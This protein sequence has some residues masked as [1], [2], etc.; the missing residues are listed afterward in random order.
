[1]RYNRVFLF[2][3]ADYAFD[4]F[5]VTRPPAGLG[6]VAQALEDNGT[7]YDFIDLRFGQSF[8]EIKKRIEGFKPDLVG[9]SMMTVKYENV[10]SL[11]KRVHAIGGFDIIFGGPHTS[12]LE[13]DVI[14][15][16][17]EIKY[18][19]VGEGEETIVELCR[20][21]D[22]RGIKGIIFQENGNIIKNEKRPF[23]QDIEKISF[24]RYTNFHLENYTKRAKELTLSTSRGCPY[25][26]IFCSAHLTIGKL[27]RQRSP[28]HVANEIE[29]WYS[30]GYRTFE[31]SDE[32]F[33]FNSR[34]IYEICDEIEKRGLKGLTFNIGGG[35]R[36]DRVDRALLKRMKEVGFRYIAIGVE[37]GN[38][39]I[40]E[41]LKKGEKIETIKEAIKNAHELGYDIGLFFVLG[42]P[43]ETWQDIEDAVAVAKA[44]PIKNVFFFNLLPQPKTELYEWIEK[45][46][47]FVV[48]PSKYLN[49]ASYFNNV[50]LY[51][52][53]SMDM[54]QRKKALKYTKNVR[55]QIRRGFFLCPISM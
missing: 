32:N 52:T 6:Y 38:N 34:R 42:V 10:Y 18:A 20:G 5:R 30:R 26:C 39:K 21:D 48:P 53:D 45:H 4:R 23:M 25:S 27:F 28:M 13:E 36:A 35:I 49:D 50:P 54:G 33:T 51:K 46:G 37:G 7:E 2:Y 16:C 22:L 17:P 11:I 1:M 19:V 31:I 29:Y 43:G 15:E 40:L 3:P 24:P 41:A 9:T 8:S 44:Y 47:Y 12:A 14:K 55:K